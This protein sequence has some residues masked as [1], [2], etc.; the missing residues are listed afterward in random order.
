MTGVTPC[1]FVAERFWHCARNFCGVAHSR[2]VSI[3]ALLLCKIRTSVCRLQSVSSRCLFDLRSGLGWN[4]ISRT[5]LEA[6]DRASFEHW[7]VRFMSTSLL[8]PRARFWLCP[9]ISAMNGCCV[10][11]SSHFACVWH[12]CVFEFVVRGLT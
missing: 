6:I 4:W 11:A 2:L 1:F 10:A 9:R 5:V 3:G 7:A 8:C 12:A